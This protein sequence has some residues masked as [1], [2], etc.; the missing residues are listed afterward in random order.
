MGGFL[1][2]LSILVLSVP[3]AVAVSATGD[4]LTIVAIG[5]VLPGIAY[6]SR[7]E[8]G[9]D[10]FVN[11][12]PCLAR[13][14]LALANLETAMSDRGSR[15]SGK[16]F[17]FRIPPSRANL[18]VGSGLDILSL[19]NNHIMDYGADALADTVRALSDSGLLHCGAGATLTEARRP[20]RAVVRGRRVAVLGYNRTLPR[21][22]W[23]TDSRP[24]TAFAKVETVRADVSRARE[25]NDIVIVL[26]HW[27]RE[28]THELRPYQ[29]PVASAAIEAGADLVVGA[30]PHVAHGIERMGSG[31]VAYSLGDAVFG[32]AY[33]RDE[34]S[35]VL[36]ARFGADGLREVEF[37]ALETSNANTGFAPRIR[38]GK[39]ARATLAMV[40][41]M[42][43]KLGTELKQAVSA[44]GF[45]CLRLVLA[46][47]KA[48]AGGGGPAAAVETSPAAAAG[49]P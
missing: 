37:L 11:L 4:E 23:A 47:S 31:V 2:F 38:K 35:L 24:G 25:E 32:G 12:S 8:R 48:R 36:R 3:A 22:F 9:H 10:P 43:A 1:T 41:D 26:V 42:S 17:T 14:D 33:T 28:R 34:D 27:G 49:K 13:A 19:A 21:T 46:D 29:R 45:P 44:D 6:A 7:I 18:L 20:A 39:R 5:D 30:H 16:K 40:S 15:V